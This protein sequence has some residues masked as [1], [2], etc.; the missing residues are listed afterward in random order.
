MRALRRSDAEERSVH[1]CRCPV[2]PGGGQRRY[3]ESGTGERARAGKLLGEFRKFVE[4]HVL[5]WI[6]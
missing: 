3:A 4:V 6:L 2:G 1:P 5:K